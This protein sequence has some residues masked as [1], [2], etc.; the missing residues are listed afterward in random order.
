MSY[1]YSISFGLTLITA[2]YKTQ[3]WNGVW[4]VKKE[5]QQEGFDQSLRRGDVLP[6][7]HMSTLMNQNIWNNQTLILSKEGQSVLFPP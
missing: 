7:Y 3:F 4:V 5:A 2:Y 6:L 1:N